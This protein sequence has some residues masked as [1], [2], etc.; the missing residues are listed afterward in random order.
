VPL[1]ASQM[2]SSNL[3][4]FVEHFWDKDAKRFVLNTDDAIITG[5]LITHDGQIVNAI[6][7]ETI[8]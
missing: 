6:V 4:N 5:C 3:Y 2:F 7:K 8:G 1:S